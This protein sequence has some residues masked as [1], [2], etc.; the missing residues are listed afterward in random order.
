MLTENISSAPSTT[1]SQR[2]VLI[3]GMRGIAALAVVC[4]HFYEGSHFQDFSGTR[5]ATL[6][7]GVLRN[8]WLGV[9]I[10]FV[11]SGFVIA[12]SFR[13]YQA[14]PRLF[15][16]FLLRRLIRLCPPY[17]LVI[18]LT[19]SRNFVSN[20]VI[21]DRVAP[22]PGVIHFLANA[23]F[24][25]PL[26]GVE[27]ILEIA[28]TLCAEMQFYIFFFVL[29]WIAQR[30]EPSLSSHRIN[31]AVLAL[32]IF[33]PPFL[34]SLLMK[35]GIIDFPLPGIFLS[36]WHSFFLG[37]LAYWT[38]KKDV[39]LTRYFLA[40]LMLMTLLLAVRPW[41]LSVMTSGITVGIVWLAG[42]GN[43]IYRWLN[44]SWMQYLGT[45]SYSLYLIH[46]VVGTRIMN[47]GYRVM[48]DSIV[49]FTGLF[50]LAVFCSLLAAHWL[51]LYIE[52]PALEFSKRLKVVVQ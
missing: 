50:L 7:D 51:H 32:V 44:Y 12:H 20:F 47:L 41:N 42:N 10:F 18:G 2:F 3:D 16:N 29:L 30:L 22:V 15:K 39:V 37:V 6:V 40:S 45:I 13:N 35:L 14:S 31:P 8:G 48:A 5:L 26:F 24:T 4:F 19:V 23:S 49:S 25:H 43:G 33:T 28:W 9:Q 36:D 21:T 46:I 38:L 11:I 52:K 34:L 17:W 1:E 27:S